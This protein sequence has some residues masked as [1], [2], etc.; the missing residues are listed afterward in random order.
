[1]D[2]M[3]SPLPLGSGHVANVAMVEGEGVAVPLL[4]GKT[5]REVIEI[6]QRLGINPLL[7]GSGIVLEQQPLRG[8]NVARGGTVTLRFGRIGEER[9]WLDP[10][11]IELPGK[12]LSA[13]R[14]AGRR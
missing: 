2:G 12:R 11:S 5:M 14:I 9:A 10:R 3:L 4:V 13:M 1:M 7:V 8:T 6:C